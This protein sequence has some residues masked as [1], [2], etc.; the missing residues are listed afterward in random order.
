MEREQR[1][2]EIERKVSSLSTVTASCLHL[3]IVQ[4][5]TVQFTL[6]LDVSQLDN[7]TRLLRGKERRNKQSPILSLT[8]QRRVANQSTIRTPL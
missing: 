1:V 8:L 4:H 3:F 6:K 7:S 2:D 5:R